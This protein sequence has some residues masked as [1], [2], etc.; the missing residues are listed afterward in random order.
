LIVAPDG[1]YGWK[2]EDGIT[3]K[4]LP[5]FTLAAAALQLQAIAQGVLAAGAR[6]VDPIQTA[7]VSLLN[8]LNGRGHT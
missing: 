5:P 6:M 4:D 3:A 1:A 2:F 8:R 7:D